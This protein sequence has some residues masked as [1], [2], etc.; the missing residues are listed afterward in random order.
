MEM[1]G[2]LMSIHQNPLG[3]TNGEMDDP[4]E[5]AKKNEAAC[6]GEAAAGEGPMDLQKKDN[7][8]ALP[9]QPAPS[10]EDVHDLLSRRIVAL[11][12]KPQSRWRRLLGLILGR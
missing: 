7:S 5:R 1:M 10:G 6:P 3:E 2:R 12:H 9:R 8:S 11:T 4:D